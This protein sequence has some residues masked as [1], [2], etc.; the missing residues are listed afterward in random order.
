MFFSFERRGSFGRSCFVEKV[1]IMFLC[2]TSLYQFL[3]INNIFHIK[4]KIYKLFTFF[5]LASISA[6]CCSPPK[7]IPSLINLSIHQQTTRPSVHRSIHPFVHPSIRPSVHRS[8]RPSVRPSI[9]SSI[10]LLVHS[11]ASTVEQ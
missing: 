4:L 6:S 5:P 7:N 8:V 2:H 10:H 9:R 3:L 11:I 1:V